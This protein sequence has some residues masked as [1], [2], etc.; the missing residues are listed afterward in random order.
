MGMFDYLPQGWE[1]TPM[2]D[3]ISITSPDPSDVSE[4][5]LDLI[6]LSLVQA[7]TRLNTT[8]QVRYP[9]LRCNYRF[10]PQVAMTETPEDY[11]IQPDEQRQQSH[12]PDLDLPTPPRIIEVPETDIIAEIMG[13]NQPCALMRMS[14]DSPLFSNTLTA[15]VSGEKPNDWLKHKDHSFWWPDDEL[16]NYKR[17]LYQDGELRDYSY[18]ARFITNGQMHRYT[19]TTRLVNYRGDLARLV[20]NQACVPIEQV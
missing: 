20:K 1:I 16:K 9:G 8:I 17:R 3:R 7:A 6:G 12:T 14:D 4:S 15:A 19:V 10:T 2:I 5:V 18:L 13:H 11:P